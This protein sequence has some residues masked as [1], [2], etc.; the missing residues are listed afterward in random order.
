MSRLFNLLAIACV[1]CAL[2]SAYA[3]TQSNW[4]AALYFVALLVLSV[5]AAMLVHVV[6]WL[7]VLRAP[8]YEGQRNRWPTGKVGAK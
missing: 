7:P 2:V 4:P 6:E 5:L 3:M 8:V 1:V